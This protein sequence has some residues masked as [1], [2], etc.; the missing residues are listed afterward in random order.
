LASGANLRSIIDLTAATAEG[1]EKVK[2]VAV[3][4]AVYKPVAQM[5]EAAITARSA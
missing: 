5:A 2:I 3:V 4:I 1:T